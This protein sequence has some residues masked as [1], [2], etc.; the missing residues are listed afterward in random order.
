MAKEVSTRPVIEYTDDELAS[1]VSF[2]QA[3]EAAA[4]KAEVYT[5]D[6]SL[7]N[8]FKLIDSKKGKAGLV[9]VPF[10]ILRWR[11]HQGDFGDF[12]SCEVVTNRN[13]RF[14]LNDGSTGIYAQLRAFTDSH[15]G[16]QGNLVVR[17]GLTQSD[18]IS[19]VTGEPATTF[20]LST[21]A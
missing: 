19:E 5:A 7:G 13:E 2:D 8:G 17:Q 20:Y 11:F 14:I 9:G 16:L 3:L 15:N 1:I 4:S 6:E 21:S 10:I 12:V 18:Y